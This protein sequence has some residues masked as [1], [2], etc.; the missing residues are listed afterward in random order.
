MEAYVDDALRR[1]DLEM[2][3][4]LPYLPLK[5]LSQPSGNQALQTTSNAPIVKGSS[6]EEP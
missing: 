1:G 3:N 6:D 5:F 2:L 4:R